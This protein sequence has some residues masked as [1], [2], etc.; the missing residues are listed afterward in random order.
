MK[1]P[2]CPQ[3]KSENTVPIVYGLIDDFGQDEDEDEGDYELG[4]CVVTD[5]DPDYSCKDCGYKWM[6]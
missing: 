4:G 1:T 5:N 2:H 3:C 6:A